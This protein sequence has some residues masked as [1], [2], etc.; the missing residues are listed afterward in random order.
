VEDE[1]LGE[2]YGE[3]NP[4]DNLHGVMRFFE[5]IGT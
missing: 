2:G 3:E 4:R 1:E 5:A